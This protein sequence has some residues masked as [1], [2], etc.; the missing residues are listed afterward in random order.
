MLRE[1]KQKTEQ[2]YLLQIGRPQSGAEYKLASVTPAK[3]F[4]AT[5]K[6]LAITVGLNACR[7]GLYTVSLDVRVSADEIQEVFTVLAPTEIIFA[8]P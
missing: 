3:R 5:S 2:K 6:E 1:W 8:A 4:G 7:P